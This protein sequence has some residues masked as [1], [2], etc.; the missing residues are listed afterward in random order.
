[1]IAPLAQ[2]FERLHPERIRVHCERILR[3]IALHR[4]AAPVPGSSSA[5]VQR[6]LAFVDLNRLEALLH[7]LLMDV[8]ELQQGQLRH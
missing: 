6:Y 8:V 4:T 1:L 5:R 7:G 3:Q 2:D